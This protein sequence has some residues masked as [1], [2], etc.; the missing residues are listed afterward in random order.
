MLLLGT[1]NLPHE[2]ISSNVKNIIADK[3]GR[4]K[5]VYIGEVIHKPRFRGVCGSSH[6]T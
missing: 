5:A 1:I 3:P 2:F 6:L 4:N